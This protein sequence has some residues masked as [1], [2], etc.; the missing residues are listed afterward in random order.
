MEHMKRLT[1]LAAVKSCY[2]LI[3]GLTCDGNAELR[4]QTGCA[5]APTLHEDERC[6]TFAVLLG[7]SS[8]GAHAV[9]SPAMPWLAVQ[10]CSVRSS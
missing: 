6:I 10:M 9:T 3:G 7:F 5:L 8:R 1:C 4:A 2:S